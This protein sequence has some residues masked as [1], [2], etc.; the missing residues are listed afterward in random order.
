MR[1]RTSFVLLVFLLSLIGA[2]TSASANVLPAGTI[3][4]IRTTEPIFGDSARPGSRVRGVVDRRVTVR[5]HVIIPNGSP[6]TL[7][8]V[9]RSSNRHRVDLSVHSIRVGG[10]RYT[11]STNDVRLGGTERGRRGLV[12]AG[13]GG[14][15]GGMLGGGPGAA[16]GATTGAGVGI[17][18][19]G[20]GR[21]QL[22]V[23][24][25]TPLQF[26][27]NRAKRIGR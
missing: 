12:G 7:E 4:H 9:G 10:T 13:V 5:R 6:A 26:R 21:T 24:P 22:S 1:P 16:V 3:L 2:W 27:V 19:A 11:L 23:P 20:S 15:V 25:H 18:S 14:A 17:V 8:V